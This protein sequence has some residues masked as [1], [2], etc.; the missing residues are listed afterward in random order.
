ML[1]DDLLRTAAGRSPDAGALIVGGR[2]L[3]FG[4]LDAAVDQVAGGLASLGVARGDRV[5]VFLENGVDA[6]LAILGAMRAAAIAVPLSPAIKADKLAYVL[7]DAE[8]AALITDGRR[9]STAID[10]CR[11]V[12][13]RPA[14]VWTSP[15]AEPS[16]V[17]AENVIAFDGLRTSGAA[18]PVRTRIDLDLAALIYTSGSTGSPKGVMLSHAGVIA[19]TTSINGYLQNTP[20]DVILDAL[21]LSFDYGLYQLFLAFQAGS[22]IVLERSFAYPNVVL[23]LMAREGVTGLPIVP[24]MAG[25]L[26]RHDLAAADLSALRY[27]TNTGAALPPAHI[28]AFRAQL[29]GVR[30]FSMYGLTECKR[31]SYLAP[32][33]IDRRPTSVGRPMGDVEVFVAAEDGTL[34][35]EGEGELVVRGPNVMPG[36]WRAPE[37]TSRRFRPGFLPG[38]RLVFTGDRFRI[39]EDGFMYF[40]GR[41]DDMIKSRGQLVSP[42]EVENVLYE[43]PGVTA[44]AVV[45]VDNPLV[46]TAL[47]AIVCL[48]SRT[49]LS[50]RDIQIHCA[51]RLED[52]MIPDSVEFVDALPTTDSGKIMRR[53]LQGPPAVRPF[54]ATA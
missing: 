45:G 18:A 49:G 32:E 1:V 8:P 9:A 28:A 37:E 29:P 54:E 6:V 25:L 7:R 17:A 35:A 5:A 13:Q 43:I 22:R 3:T 47:K 44:A 26:Q 34:L 23:Q 24:M 53:A 39:D 48:D 31:V 16:V 52:F 46:G 27:I 41:L 20:A 19:A 38:E 12:A 2:R 36:Y 42:K 4:Q 33:E 15:H 51:R 11:R 50:A 30:I 40:Q 10:A 21:P 14:L